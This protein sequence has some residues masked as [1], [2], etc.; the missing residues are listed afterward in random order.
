MP[1]LFPFSI[2]IFPV[3]NPVKQRRNKTKIQKSAAIQ[4]IL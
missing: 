1:V 3:A 4:C 2:Y